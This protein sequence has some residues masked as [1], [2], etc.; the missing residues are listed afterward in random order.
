MTRDELVQ[1]VTDAM[2]TLATAQDA[3]DAFNARAENNV[4]ESLQLALNTVEYQLQSRAYDACEGA[5][6]CGLS[7]YT[8]LFIVD[9]ITY[10]GLL[11]VEYNR[12]DKTYYYVDGQEFTYR[13]A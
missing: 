12:H 13:V 6:N 2:S 4:Y 9:D 3:L 10:I 1:A 8:Q 7:E 5:G 11:E